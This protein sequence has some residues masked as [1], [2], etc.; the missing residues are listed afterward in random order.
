MKI[1]IDYSDLFFSGVYFLI[2]KG[3]VVYVGESEKIINRI[4]NHRDKV[5]DDIRVISTKTFYWLDDI[6]FRLYFERR[7]I[8]FFQPEYNDKGKSY[9]VLLNNFLMRRHLWN[10]NPQFVDVV[11]NYCGTEK[12][13]SSKKHTTFMQ[14]WLNHRSR[15]GKLTR[16]CNYEGDEYECKGYDQFF[17]TLDL[18]KKIYID[19]GSA[20]HSLVDVTLTRGKLEKMDLN[21]K[22]FRPLTKRM[23]N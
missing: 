22:M 9:P 4:E 12:F 18:T 5:F 16:I 17:R 19:G 21:Q 14:K 8:Y 2:N 13:N 7:C 3:K 1:N 20:F 10:Q 15:N 11:S 6:W 23:H